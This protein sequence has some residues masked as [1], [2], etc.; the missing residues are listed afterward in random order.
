MKYKKVEEKI[1]KV[2]DEIDFLFE[3]SDARIKK[4]NKNDYLNN[5]KIDL[6]DKISKFIT[7][8]YSEILNKQFAINL[9]F[10]DSKM[11]EM[12]LYMVLYCYANNINDCSKIVRILESDN[13]LRIKSKGFY[14]FKLKKFLCA[15]A[16]GMTSTKEWNSFDEIKNTYKITSLI[17]A[18]KEGVFYNIKEFEEDLLANAE[19]EV[20]LKNNSSTP[21]VYVQEDKIYITLGLRIKF[22]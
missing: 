4:I 14:E 15:I 17:N 12:L 22:N 11:E 5:E 20:K 13:P 10:I 7:F 9:M 3:I 18:Q 19:F 16:M 6:L 2:S 8:K 1:L 21:F